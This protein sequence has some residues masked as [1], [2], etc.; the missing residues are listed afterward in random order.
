ML[1]IECEGNMLRNL[2]PRLAALCVQVSM[3]PRQPD[4]EKGGRPGNV[5]RRIEPVV[6]TT[7]LCDQPWLCMARRESCEVYQE[8]HLSEER[9][10]H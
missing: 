3:T 4:F 5:S 8:T 10:Y 6:I 7:S 1:G 2:G 9:R